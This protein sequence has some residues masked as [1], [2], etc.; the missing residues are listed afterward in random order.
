VLDRY[1][2]MFPGHEEKVND[3]LDAFARDAARQT[4]D[5]TVLRVVG[6]NSATR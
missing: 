6:G 2:H 5:G 3:A 4:R 1:G